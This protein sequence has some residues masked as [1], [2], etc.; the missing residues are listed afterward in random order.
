MPLSPNDIQESFNLINSAPEMIEQYTAQ[1]IQQINMLSQQIS[2]ASSSSISAMSD[3]SLKN[4]ASLLLNKA[5]AIPDVITNA[6]TTISSTLDQINQSNQEIINAANSLQSN[7]QQMNEVQQMNHIQSSKKTYNYKKAQLNTNFSNDN[8]NMDF[9]FENN[10]NQIGPFKNVAE[11][12]NYLEGISRTE[13]ENTLLEYVNDAKSQEEISSTMESFYEHE[14]NSEEKIEI[15]VGIWQYIPNILKDD[16]SQNNIIENKIMNKTQKEKLK[17][18]VKSSTKDIKKLAEKDI[19]NKKSYNLKKQA[20]HDTRKDIVLW[21]PDSRRIDPFTGQYI[22]DWHVVERNKGWGF[23]I[24]DRWDIDFESLW[25]ENIMD[26]YS[27]PYKDENG[28]WVGGYLEKRF[29]IDRW[30]PEENKMQLNTNEKRKPR[31]ASLGN[32]EARMEVYRGN[33][34]KVYNWKEASSKKKS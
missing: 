11:L 34:D 17:K 28:E 13:A 10:Q 18:F 32:Y 12:S 22:S 20:Q 4:Q 15:L 14:L 7:I 29:E 33:E 21:G 27:R 24:G 25:R 5:Q 6:K 8:M 3:P 1:Y 2:Q 30:V 26:K 31:P 16:E 9:D 19:T 23:R